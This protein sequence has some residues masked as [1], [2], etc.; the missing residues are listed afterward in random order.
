MRVDK[1]DGD[2]NLVY[3]VFQV[4]EEGEKYVARGLVITPQDQL[5][6][7]DWVLVLVDNLGALGLHTL[8]RLNRVVQ[9]DLYT[10]RRQSVV[11]PRV[12]GNVLS[13]AHVNNQDPREFTSRSLGRFLDFRER[14]GR[15][16]F[17]EVHFLDDWSHKSLGLLFRAD[18]L[19][20]QIESA[21]ILAFDVLNSEAP[22][23]RHVFSEIQMLDGS[24]LCFSVVGET[25]PRVAEDSNL[26]VVSVRSKLETVLIEK[27]RN[28]FLVAGR[29]VLLLVGGQ[30]DEVLLGGLENEGLD[31][32]YDHI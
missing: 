7:P 20:V 8:G 28:G 11:R 30:L 2:R 6:V 26:D 10:G 23:D 32:H 21:D 27:G 13:R 9:I 15:S 24:L 17:L 19:N 3:L 16:V 31:F 4:I 12:E 1:I 18:K 14:S 25:L 29:A 22:L 5:L